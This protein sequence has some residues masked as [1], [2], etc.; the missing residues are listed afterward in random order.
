MR[1]FLVFAS[2]LLIPALAHGQVVPRVELHPFQSRSPTNE[3]F[4][5][6]AADAQ[7]VTIGGELRLP[8]AGADR[9]PAVVLLHASGGIGPNVQAWVSELNGMGIATFLV[10]SFTGR[11]IASTQADQD[12]LSRLAM[13]VDAYR[14]LDLLSAHPRIDPARVAVMGFSRGGGAAHWAAIK[15]FQAMHA[16]DA[17]AHY[18]LHIAFYPTCN[19]DFRDALDIAAPVRIVHGTA[20]D[21][22]PIKEC[23]ELVGRLRE[24]GR[25]ASILEIEGAPTMIF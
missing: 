7:A 20:D 22:I 10:D 11:G 1:R 25:D 3:Q 13:V 19:R 5:T 16:K 2:L 15:R 21:Y 24:A 18:A 12:V 23:R 6:G 4:L 14:A 17:R 9:L 8:I